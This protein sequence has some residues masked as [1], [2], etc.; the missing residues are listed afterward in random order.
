MILVQYQLNILDPENVERAEKLRETIQ[1]TIGDQEVFKW[2]DFDRNIYK[3]P[4]LHQLFIQSYQTMTSIDFDSKISNLKDRAESETDPE[5]RENLE[6]QALDIENAK[7]FVA[8]A[9]VNYEYNIGQL[10]TTYGRYKDAKE[11]LSNVIDLDSVPLEAYEASKVIL[12]ALTA[13]R[14]WGAIASET[15]FY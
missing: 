6:L 2:N 15:Q 3:L 11:W 13:Q 10:L 9:R 12:G 14:D 7:L 8:G 4:Q 1:V 5:K